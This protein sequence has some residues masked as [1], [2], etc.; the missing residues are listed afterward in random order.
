LRSLAHS[1]ILIAFLIC[2]FIFDEYVILIA[3]LICFFIFDE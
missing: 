2:F 3:F 1:V